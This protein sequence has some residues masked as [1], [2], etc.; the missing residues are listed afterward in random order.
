MDARCM[1][2]AAL[3]LA[4]VQCAA[5]GH[6]V[7]SGHPTIDYF[8]TAGAMEPDDADAHYTE[9]LVRLPGIGTSYPRPAAP[10]KPPDAARAGVAPAARACRCDTPLFL[11][12]QALFKILPDDD[13]RF[14][15]VLEAVPGSVLLLFEGRHRVA[16]TTLMKRLSGTLAAKGLAP[17]ERLRV[18]R[19]CLARG[20]PADQRCL[21]RDARHASL[22]GRQ[23]HA[24]RDRVRPADRQSARANS[25]ADGRRRRCCGWR[26]PAIRSPATKTTTCRS[27]RVSQPIGA[28][29]GE[30]V[31]RMPVGARR[32][33]RRCGADRR[34]RRLP[35]KCRE[36]ESLTSARADAPSADRSSARRIFNAVHK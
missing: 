7:T 28:W 34:A 21:R 13:E 6:P 29:R 4:R 25:C 1:V 9:K 15:R 33:V 26:A 17:R 20:L 36:R 31:G 23:Q 22:V 24:R 8:F 3:R 27:Q 12:P 19:A 11:C 5:W 16:T 32:A 35:A 14:A 2:L 10:R 30:I 18:L